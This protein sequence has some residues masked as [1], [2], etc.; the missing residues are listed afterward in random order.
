MQRSILITNSMPIPKNI[1]T[2]LIPFLLSL[3]TSSGFAQI[4][5]GG[6]PLPVNASAYTRNLQRLETPFVEMPSFDV[7]QAMLRSEAEG[8]KFKS[9]EFAHKFHVFLRPD[10]S[11]VTFNTLDNRKIWR[12]GIRSRKAYSLN[13]LF[14]KFRYPKE[15]TCLCTTPTNLRSWDHTPRKT[16][17]N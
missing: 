8:K 17:P 7:Q 10:N 15:R 4:S 13:I 9:L 16:I 2:I 5:H 11:G 14:S 1:Q 12:V 6:R 3:L